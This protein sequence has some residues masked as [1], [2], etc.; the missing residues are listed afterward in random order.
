VRWLFAA[1]CIITQPKSIIKEG[2]MAQA[3]LDTTIAALQLS[4][5]GNN[6]FKATTSLKT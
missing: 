1:H 4:I 6:S 5:V 2:F 3:D